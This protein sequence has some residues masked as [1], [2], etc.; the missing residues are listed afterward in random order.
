M[1]HKMISLSRATCFCQI[2]LCKHSGCYGSIAAE[3][4]C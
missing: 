1:I 2:T 4:G 3:I